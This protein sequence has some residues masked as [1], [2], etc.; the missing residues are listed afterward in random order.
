[1][2]TA[3]INTILVGITWSLI[4]VKSPNVIK[5]AVK[6]TPTIHTLDNTNNSSFIIISF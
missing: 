6:Q 4:K 1:M 5:K 2:N 3:W